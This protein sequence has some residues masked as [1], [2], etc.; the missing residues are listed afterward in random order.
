LHRSSLRFAAAA[1]LSIGVVF[2]A[3]AQERAPGADPN[4][5]AAPAAATRMGEVVVR[6]RAED[7]VGTAQSASE[8]FVGWEQLDAR[9]LLRPG[10]LLETI[11]GMIA[12]QHSGGGK[13]NQYFLRGFNLDHGTDLA[14]GIDGVPLNLPSHGHGQGYTDLNFLIPELVRDV[15]FRKGPYFA[16]R[17]DFASAGSFDFHYFDAL[18]KAIARAEGG[19]H[20]Y[21]RLLVA[22]TPELGEGRLLYALDGSFNQ[23]PWDHPDDFWKA[24]GVLRY[25]QGDETDG[26]WIQGL[27]YYGDWGATDQV[28]ER[29]I[30]AGIIGQWGSLDPSSAGKSARAQLA[31]QWRRPLGK[32]RLEVPAYVYYYDLELYSNFTYYLDDPDQGDQFEQKDRRVVAGITP[33]YAWEMELL[34][35]TFSNRVGM[36]VRNDWI[37]NGL[38]STEQRNRWA[39]TRHDEIVQT[40]AGWFLE[41]QVA[42]TDWFRTVTGGRVDFYSFDVDADLSANSGDTTDAIASPKLSLI[43]GPWKKTE[44]YLNG[45]FGFHSNDARGVNGNIDPVTGDPVDGADPLVR[46]KGAEVGIRTSMLPGLQ[47]SVSLWKLE[48]DSELL[49][50]G[51]A[52]TN[53]P[54][55]ESRRYGI[56]FANYYQPVEWLSFDF[57]LALSHARFRESAPEGNYIPGSLETALGA[58]ITVYDLNGFFGTVRVRHFGARPLTED[59]SVRSNPSTIVNLRAGYAFDEQWSLA[60]DVFNL[61]DARP[62]DIDYYYTSR[63]PGEPAEGVDDVHTHP[64]ESRAVRAQITWNF[65]AE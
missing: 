60:V 20:G 37:R 11:P 35:R 9:P 63:L 64:A 17:G 2:D 5:P 34:G 41:S 38:Y 61:F 32:G 13:A 25:S 24:N 3:R 52:G 56:E 42:W 59:D 22:D 36:Q 58:G 65:G 14:I 23:G 50:I 7:L 15:S 33:T 49:F 48:L 31:G 18:P 27:G 16:D 21:G 4:A 53:E 55:R 26:F 51:D 44:L 57:D 54:T 30:D 47:S 45:G 10:E 39:T 1:L 6:G 43:F 19:Q 12:T 62:S 8:G 29:A 28:A 46:S 40:S